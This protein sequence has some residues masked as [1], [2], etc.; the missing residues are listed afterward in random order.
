MKKWRNKSVCLLMILIV[1]LSVMS[2]CNELQSHESAEKMVLND[3]LMLR[4]LAT[5]QEGQEFTISVDNP[6]VSNEQISSPQ[7]SLSIPQ[8][9]SQTVNTVVEIATEKVTSG[10]RIRQYISEGAGSG[11]IISSDGYIV[12][13]NHVIDKAS[14]ITVR[15]TNGEIYTPVLVGCDKQTDIAVLK[16]SAEDLSAA[17]MGDSDSLV[18]GELAVAVGNPLGQLGGTVTEGIISALNR[19]I[20]L[21]GLEMNL[22]QTTAAINPGNS[23]GGLFNGQAQ[24]IGIVN[25]KCSGSD[26]EGL[27]FAIPINSVKEVIK[28]IISY[29]YVRGRV[30]LG[31]TLVDISDLFTALMYGV[32]ETG[33][34][35][36]L[37]TNSSYFQVGDRIVSINGEKVSKVAQVNRLL[38]GY[39]VGD[40]VKFVVKRDNRLL[41]LNVTLAEAKK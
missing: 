35:V 23:G 20:T 3:E 34:Y 25:A 10:D 11:V 17:I 7:V 5:D 40:R 36:A 4:S 41:E 28:Q 8:I 9:A 37:T 39:K 1:S 26:I 19:T 21:D 12:T 15:L 33:V 13:N 29:G 30:D 32:R 16:I 6:P 24:L 2:G 18:V 38:K 31:V 22:L 27:G 14:R